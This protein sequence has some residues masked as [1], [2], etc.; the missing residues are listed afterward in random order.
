M[1]SI[2]FLGYL[3]DFEKII[4]FKILFYTGIRYGVLLGLTIGDIHDNY[5]DINNSY[6]YR[7]KKFCATKNKHSVRKVYIHKRL[8]SYIDEY[9]KIIYR[10]RKNDRLFNKTPIRI[11]IK[12]GPLKQLTSWTN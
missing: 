3:D 1:N 12:I 9:I 2:L 7:S 5:I 6:D 10:P 11:Y 8:K 4:T